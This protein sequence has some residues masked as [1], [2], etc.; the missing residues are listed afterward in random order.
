M[1][2]FSVLK[3]AD[4]IFVVDKSWNVRMYD[5]RRVL[6]FLEKSIK[7]LNVEKND[8]RVGI[9]SFDSRTMIWFPLH[10]YSTESLLRRLHDIPYHA[11]ITLTYAALNLVEQDL[12]VKHQTDRKQIALVMLGGPS[13]YF[14]GR[15]GF[16]LTRRAAM[17]L[18]DDGVHVV[19]VGVSNKVD[20]A[21]LKAIASYPKL[22]N[23]VQL[24]SFHQLT[25]SSK[26]ILGMAPKGNRRLR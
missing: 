17:R 18:H 8:V 3:S 16:F 12:H 5:W 15:N 25:E 19:A 7:E 4:V 24:E 10:K 6:T 23:V 21:E 20:S 14:G 11:G 1:R 13:S 22:T 2:Y 26:K 9:V